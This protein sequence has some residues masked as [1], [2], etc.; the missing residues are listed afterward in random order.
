MYDELGPILDDY[1]IFI[2]PANNLPAV[3]ADVDLLN[4]PVVINGRE[5]TGRDLLLLFR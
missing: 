4:D 5:V 3:M 1:D 2:C